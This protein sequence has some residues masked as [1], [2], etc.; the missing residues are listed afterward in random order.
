V[1]KPEFRIKPRGP[2]D[3][4]SSLDM[5]G[6]WQPVAHFLHRDGV[7]TVAFGLDHSFAP[8]GV[9]LRM[10][11][12]AL[13][14]RVSD[15]ADIDA[16][17]R[18]VARMFSLDADAT[19]YPLVG[20]RDPAIGR[21]MRAHSGLRPVLFPSPYEAAVWAVIS[22]RI[23]QRQAARL[24]AELSEAHGD[25]VQVDGKA[26]RTLPP[27]R[28]LLRIGEARG[29]S[30]EK[31]ERMHA[32]ARAA[33]DGALDAV[34]LRAMGYEAA[35][36]TLQE[37]RGIGP[38][39]SSGIYLRACGVTEPFPADEPKT[40][41]ALADAHGLRDVPAGADLERIVARFEPFGMWVSVLLRVA[42]N[43][44]TMGEDEVS[45]ASRVR[46]A[47][48]SPTRLPRRERHP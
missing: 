8:A 16:A 36:R 30:A 2:F 6:S 11:G 26:A 5:L 34:R 47:R 4:N 13:V 23:S 44:G 14:G 22:Q 42:A 35:L 3:W 46:H 27:P 33:I 31:I 29:L 19:D 9:Q 17:E 1:P 7:V 10:E 40:L 45:P 15:L 32:V 24:K 41:R 18:Q 21:I 20:R 25:L 43:R 38:F 37:I 12:D 48:L 28:A 39:W